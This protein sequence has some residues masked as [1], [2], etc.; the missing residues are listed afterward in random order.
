MRE[1]GGTTGGLGLSSRQDIDMEIQRIQKLNQSNPRKAA[2][3]VLRAIDKWNMIFE[4]ATRLGVYRTALERGLSRKQAAVLAKESTINFN[5]K[6]TSGPIVNGLYMFSNASIQGTTKV[7]RAMKNPKVAAAV[8]ISMFAAVESANQWNDSVDPE[9]RKKVTKW[10]RSANLVIMFPTED[11]SANYMTI[12]ISWGLKPIKMSAEYISDLSKG[13]IDPIDGI[14]GILTSVLQAYNPL[15]G[16]ESL[17]RT[18]TPTVLKTPVEISSNRG[19]HGNQIKPAYDVDAPASSQYFASLGNSVS[20]RF[21]I[22]ATEELSN[23]NVMEVSPADLDYAFNQY[24]GGV[25]RSVNK[26]SSA[27]ANIGEDDPLPANQRP[28]LSRFF[29]TRTQEQVFNDMFYTERQQA[30]EEKARERVLDKRRVQPIYEE[31]QVL[32]QSGNKEAAQSLVDSL[33]DEDYEVYKKLKATDTRRGNT[34]AQIEQY[35]NVRKI[36]ELMAEGKRSEAQRIVDEMT[37][38][39]YEAY[40][41]AK[42]ALGVDY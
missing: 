28:I 26:L 36:E 31:A 10:D 4:D 25:G 42:A 24:I 40:K 14:Q 16:D 23:R 38:E 37:D 19:W 11:G 6:G 13:Q 17:L 20:G 32:L 30:D 3:A 34:A 39:E 21:F 12:P 22:N 5:K 27:I 15:A 7:L 1:D 35:S 2:E 29:R 9:W 41:K 33:S 8:T 18:L